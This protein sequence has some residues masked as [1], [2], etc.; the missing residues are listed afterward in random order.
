MLDLFKT[1]R[2][3]RVLHRFLLDEALWQHV[4]RG[5]PFLRGLTD[6]EWQSL[7]ELCV[8]FLQEKEIYGARGFIPTDA[9]RLSIAA[10]AC[11]PILNLGLDA[12]QGWVGIVVYPGEFKVRREEM[13]ENGVVHE[14]DDALSGEAWPGGPVILSWQDIK[15][16]NAGYN[17]VIHEFA[18]KLHMDRGHM[19]DFPLPHAHMDKG[20]WL[21]TWDAAYDEFCIEVDRGIHTL[22]DPYA[23]EQPAEFFAVLS[24]AFFTLPQAVRSNYPELYR[25][26]ALFYRQDPAARLPQ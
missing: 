25:Q 3:K 20:Q 17:V 21:S 24:E 8:L 26:L 19:D 10:Q 12:Y 1:W 5:L 9:V 6:A 4:T 11:L 23:S 7:K 15:L 16:G 13:D 2:R 18:H 22:L 14:Y